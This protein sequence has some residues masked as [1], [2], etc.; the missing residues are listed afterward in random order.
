MNAPRR[1]RATAYSV[2]FYGL[3]V[4]TVT[5][6][7]ATTAWGSQAWQI[8]GLIVGVLGLRA[9]VQWRTHTITGRWRDQR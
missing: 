5:F 1:L 7:V 8:L 9:L 3:A 4:L 6:T 2:G